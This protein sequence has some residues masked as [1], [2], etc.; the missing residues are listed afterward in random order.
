MRHFTY[1][2][3]LLF[4]GTGLLNLHA[5]PT[6]F[7]VKIENVGQAFSFTQSGVFNTPV[8]AMNP[9]PLFPG[10]TYEFSFDAAPGS[11]LSFATMFVQSND[12]FYAPDEAGIALYDGSGNPV[13]GDLTDQLQLWDAGTEINQPPGEGADQAPGQSGPNTGAAD[14]DN[15]VRLVNDGYTYPMNSEV[16]RFTLSHNGGTS[17]TASIENVSTPNTLTLSDGSTVAVPLAPG[18]FVVHS[19]P[20]PL[21]TAGEMD[22]GEGLEG[23][24]EDG[25]PML[26]HETL[27]TQTGITSVLAPGVF[28]VHSDDDPLFTVGEMD[29]GE[30]LEAIAEDGNPG[31][32]ANALRLSTTSTGGAFAVPVG[33]SGPAPALPGDAYE[34]VVASGPSG[35]LSFATMFVQSNDLFF[36]PDGMGIPLFDGGMP[37]NGDVTAQIELWDAGTEANEVPGVGPNQAPRQSGPDTGA[38]DPD[39]T[40]RLVNDGYMYP[41]N[42]SVIK[43]TVTPIESIRFTVRVENVSDASTLDIGGGETVPVPMAPGVWALHSSPA[44]LFT[45]GEP[46]RGYGLEAIA[47]DGDPSMLNMILGGKMGTPSGAFNTPVGAS[48]PGPLFPG[49]AYEFDIVAAPGMNLSLATMFVQSNDLFYAPGEM[50][51]PLFD[52]NGYPVSGDVTHYFDLWDPGTEENEQP[53]VGMNQAPRQSGPNTGAMDSDNTVRLVN[54]IYTYPADESVLKVTIQPESARLQI[55]HAAESQTVQVRVNGQ[56]LDGV[57]AYQTATP[58]LELPAETPLEIELIPV[59]GPTPADQ[60][61]TFDLQL[62]AGQTYVAAVYGT[63]D[64]SDDLPVEVAL[65]SPAFETADAGSVALSAFS[66]ATDVVTIDVNEGGSPIFTDVA[67]GTFADYLDFPAAAYAIQIDAAGDD[68]G[69]Y[70]SSFGFWSG[71]SAVIFTTGSH[72]SGSFQP[73]VALDN[74]GTYPLFATG[75]LINDSE[76]LNLTSGTDQ[77]EALSLFPNPAYDQ[78]TLRYQL[79]ARSNVSIRLI[80][81]NGQ[82]LRNVFEGVSEE[83]FYQ[84]EENLSNL[85]KGLYWYSITTNEETKVVKLILQ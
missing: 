6:Y 71:R 23:I 32:L 24:A 39:N 13:E 53:G 14:P 2:L 66:G 55:I 84:I 42:A 19:A 43:V 3:I 21:F 46:D 11:Y 61:E 80:N 5:Q 35:K 30:G 73:W 82:V 79:A 57:V 60:V 40:V 62:S 12:L 31:M 20:A 81:S 70:E 72:E 74:G 77:F 76:Q 58:Y 56:M 7:K 38:A 9:A 10:E 68:L 67:Y 63:F 27:S 85:P 51:V 1:L 59:G 28:V 15:T 25:N 18:A 47:E 29:R 49:E 17:F 4:A 65:L 64:D 8:G 36:A 54:D 45:V 22:R 48:G 16:I 33:G 69:T 50:G 75:N 78:V 44:P 26:M 52:E 83:G 41:M 37:I 34:F